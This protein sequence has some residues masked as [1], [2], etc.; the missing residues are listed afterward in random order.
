MNR[1]WPPLLIY[2]SIL[3]PAALGLEA[4]ALPRLPS[5]LL[6]AGLAILTAAIQGIRRVDQGWQ[7]FVQ[8]LID[9]IPEPVYIKDA[10]ARF[11][12]VNEAFAQERRTRASELVGL[13]SFDLSP[14]DTMSATVARE[15]E[16]VLA[17]KAVF[18]EQH[19]TYPKTGE[20]CF[21]L[22]SKRL[23]DGP[24]GVPVIIGAHFDIT[25]LRQTEACLQAALTRETAQSE[26]IQTYMQ[27]LIDVIPQPVY[28]K[29]EHSRYLML[30]QAFCKDRMLDGSALLG[31]TPFDLAKDSAHAERVV[32][33]DCEVLGG[34]VI[35]KEE[36]LP[37][38][39]TG[40]PRFRIISKGCCENSE[41]RPVIVGAN[42]D[43]TS[44]REAEIRWRQASAA[45]SRFLATMSHEIRTPLSGVIG[46]LQLALGDEQ[47]STETR[48]FLDNG[49]H[50]AESLLGILNDILDFSKIEAG[51]L[52]LERINFDLHAAIHSALSPLREQAQA[53]NLYF[54]IELDPDLAQP[55][56]GDPMRLRQIIVNL[57]GNAVKFTEA[58]GVFCQFSIRQEQDPDK[59]ELSVSI[60]DTGIGIPAEVMPRLFQMFQQADS[61]TT[62][63]FGGTGLGLAISRQLIE[64][65]GGSIHADSSLGKGS[66]FR[67]TLPLEKGIR[68]E[69]PASALPPHTRSLRVLYAEDV[70]VNQLIVRTQLKQMGH[71]VD[72]VDN[73][74]QAVHALAQSDFDL[75]LMDGRM[76][77]M[78]GHEATRCI[79]AGGLPDAP[80]RNPMIRI[81][82][83]TANATTEDRDAC[84]AAGMDGVLTKP[85]R[86]AAL[87]AALQST[88]E[89]FESPLPAADEETPPAML[90][91]PPSR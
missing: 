45:K 40:E 61:S 21:R 68:T 12:M 8:R 79:R 72:V 58:G 75:V 37:H 48:N 80:V 14:D 66:C 63:R 18:K 86:E 10:N 25:G 46:T 19:T 20:E 1:R 3:I 71:Q 23:C 16:E 57:A 24:E 55:L 11:L 35:L 64:A 39:V 6:L 62:R 41:G 38:P 4:L 7:G 60:R 30:N 44:W 43:I 73:G 89:H 32:A 47:L 77:E 65:M 90:A 88:I 5:L 36:C 83:L 69:P 50:S 91:H 29:D 34:R 84:F 87:H 52:Q 9:A 22:V 15:D 13:T 2:A 42:F 33:E 76:P 26:R 74:L 82:A 67:F 17:G 51:Q 56:C 49:L 53:K 54:R 85:V 78:D 28:V 81:V 59:V 31:K 70:R 27:R